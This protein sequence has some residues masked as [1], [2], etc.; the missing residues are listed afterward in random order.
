MDFK[1]GLERGPFSD[2]QAAQLHEALSG[3]DAGQLQWLSGYFA[4][5][6][7]SPAGV[8]TVAGEPAMAA[9]VTAQKLTVLYGS[10]TGN[11]EGLAQNLAALAKAKGIEV[12]VAD[13][14][15]FK[16]RDLKKVSNLA[17]LVST[18]GIGEPLFR[19]RICISSCMAKSARPLAYKVFGA[20]PGRQQLRGF[21]PDGK[22]V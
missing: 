1:K 17:V 15:S 3:L 10:H 20:G 4:G 8:A 16:T 7:A 5:V 22:R 18:H 13:M 14:A 2:K 6:A 21:L 12:E 9:A 11:C 19:P